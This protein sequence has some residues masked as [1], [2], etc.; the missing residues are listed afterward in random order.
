MFGYVRCTQ[1]EE[2]GGTAAFI[3]SLARDTKNYTGAELEGLV[4]DAASHALVRVADRSDIT[5]A[6]DTSDIVICADDFRHAL[7]EASGRECTGKGLGGRDVQCVI[8]AAC[9]PVSRLFH[10]LGPKT[11]ISS[12]ATRTAS[13]TLANASSYGVTFGLLASRFT[14][15]TSRRSCLFCCPAA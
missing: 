12:T 3:G 10:S 4:R 8:V 14:T 15:A 9:C 6:V 11:R 13:L 5:K 2:G 7:A 1:E